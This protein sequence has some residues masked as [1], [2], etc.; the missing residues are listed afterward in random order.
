MKQK[1]TIEDVAR[2]A[3]VSK[4]SVSRVINNKGELSSKTR[5]RI[6]KA[7]KDLGYRPSRLA[8]AMKTSQSGLIG[9]VV[10]DITNPYFP[11]VVRGVQDAASRNQY[12]VLVRN[13]DRS[14]EIEVLNDLVSYGIDGLITF[15]HR[16]ND[17][18]VADFANN[19]SPLVVI[20]REFDDRIDHQHV[21]RLM[22]DHIQGAQLATNHLIRLGHKRIGMLTNNL[23]GGRQMRR[24]HGYRQ[25]LQNADIFFDATLIISER[26][27][28]QGG[29][30][31]AKAL[32]SQQPDVTAI[33]G[34][35]DL[36]AIGA[37][38]ACKDLNRSVPE[39][40]SVI[41]F[42]DLKA[43]SML[44]PSLS[45]IRVDK[46]EIGRLAFEQVLSLMND[47]NIS[48]ETI[49]LKTVLMVRESTKKR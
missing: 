2:A 16:A 32:L 27:T 45:S 48:R 43:A 39:D 28:Y 41:G 34:Y 29:Y 38:R 1:V 36:M 19:F 9:L 17:Q 15:L 26:P 8:Q 4:Q 12:T 47:R 11:E 49:Q 6:Q 30:N 18:S 3:G 10:S 33:F 20:N 35:N 42:D 13:V 37:M 25:A 46:Y 44:T 23:L 22:V 7:I 21:A 40:I 5:E 14:H 31:A 24:V